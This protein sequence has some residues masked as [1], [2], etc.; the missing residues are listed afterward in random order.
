[1]THIALSSVSVSYDEA[2]VLADVTL[3]VA[4]GHWLA[5]VGPNGA[6]K[7]T[8]LRAIAGLV[9]SE[10]TVQIAG[11]SAAEIDRKRLA[12]MIAYV[13]QQPFVPVAT[14][15]TE[16]VLMGR[17]PYIP[18]FGVEGPR[19]LEVVASAIE[20]LE[21]HALRQRA[22]GSLSGG[23][24]QRVILA[25]A[26]AQEAP[27]LLLDEPTTALDVGHQQQ[28]L[29]LVDR[30]RAER[31]LT[32]V[33]CMHD[34]TLAAQYADTLLLLDG[35]RIAAQGEARNVLTEDSIRRHF[36]AEVKVVDEDDGSL[37]VYPRRV[38]VESAPEPALR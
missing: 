20:R 37:V 15:V 6:G 23:E 12:R 1:M 17:T 9:S 27:I 4:G 8:L 11:I 5:V 34:L 22:L 31:D 33:S 26:L 14:T 13:P 21:L 30:L 32:V 28:V 24:L 29:E 10:G 38:A 36:G 19:D 35:G 25:R 7:S 16:Y 18:Y 2:V 3:D